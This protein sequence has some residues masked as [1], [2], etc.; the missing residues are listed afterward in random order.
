[1]IKDYQPTLNPSPFLTA[2]PVRI[3]RFLFSA[4]LFFLFLMQT[5]CGFQL[6]R[7]RIQLIEQANS[8]AVSKISNKSYVPRL[9]LRL[10]DLLIERF[11]L[12]SVT[13]APLAKADL[14]LTFTID[15]MTRS[16]SDYSL[17]DSEK[18]YDFTFSVKGSLNVY[19]NRSESFLINGKSLGGSYSVK[20]TSTDL[21]A[22]EIDEGREE[23]LDGLS[24]TIAQ[25]LNDS[26]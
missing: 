6:N 23:A 7:N 10:R 2:H 20:T 11:N 1:M 3:G 16:K 26:F 5:G 17:D 12:D 15:S 14:V 24:N 25:N 22:S 13:I 21:S 9:D 8:I 18:T 19:D 4:L